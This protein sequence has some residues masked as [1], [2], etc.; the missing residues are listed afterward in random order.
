[1]NKEYSGIAYIGA[2]QYSITAGLFFAGNSISGSIVFETSPVSVWRLVGELTSDK[3]Q[4][5][6]G[7]AR[8]MT[9]DQDLVQ[10]TG[11][12]EAQTSIAGDGIAITTDI[13]LNGAPETISLALTDVNATEPAHEG[14]GSDSPFLGRRRIAPKQIR[15][16]EKDHFMDN[17]GYKVSRRRIENESNR[18][19]KARV[20]RTMRDPAN[21][22]KEGI[23][24]RIS[25]ALG[26]EKLKAIKI[27]YS[28]GGEDPGLA[29][30]TI[31]NSY[32]RVFSRYVSDNDFVIEM[33]G[34]ITGYSPWSLVHFI[35]ESDY[36]TA[37]LIN[38][39]SSQ[40]FFMDYSSTEL[41]QDPVR[42]VSEKMLLEKEA[43]LV[44]GSITMRAT[45]TFK[46][47][48]DSVTTYG[49][50]SIDHETARVEAFSKLDNLVDIAYLRA[51]KISYIYQSE[52]SLAD[53]SSKDGRRGLFNLEPQS[54]Y[55]TLEE[56]DAEQLPTSKGYE[57]IAQ[58]MD[59]GFGQFWGE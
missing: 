24:A 32:L 36:F 25:A 34:D 20:I 43:Y 10:V 19:M 21:S 30:L 6:T 55:G 53:L 59:S 41:V 26:L 27:S 42:E 4:F 22:T 58:I 35:N 46:N 12:T 28:Y 11:V 50:W 47:L 29:R 7:T 52:I 48:T 45:R 14:D 57:V 2:V 44:P 31:V 18:D 3:S 23:R 13:T 39:G 38:H 49:D 15:I 33:E 16:Q 8:F 40:N 9:P 17:L 56:R 54:L 5:S 51:P 37:D 1:M